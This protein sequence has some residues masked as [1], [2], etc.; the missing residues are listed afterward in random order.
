MKQIKETP[1]F[2][3]DSVLDSHIL[4]TGDGSP[5]WNND[6]EAFLTWRQSRVWKE[7]KSATGLVEATDLEDAE[8]SAGN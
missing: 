6:Y 5:L 4:P 2:P 3:F 1:C 7:I 8:G